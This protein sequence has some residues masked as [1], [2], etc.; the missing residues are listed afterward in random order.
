[1]MMLTYLV[2]DAVM[3]RSSKGRRDAAEGDRG[4]RERENEFFHG[5]SYYWSERT[6][7]NNRSSFGR[8]LSGIS[9][10]GCFGRY[11]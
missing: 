9:V 8:H 3:G 6:N 4:Y 11:I 10:K 1:M 7:R 2:A 5:G